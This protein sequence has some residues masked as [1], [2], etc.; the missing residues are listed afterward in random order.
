MKCT[1]KSNLDSCSEC[2]KMTKTEQKAVK[3]AVHQELINQ[4]KREAYQKGIWEMYN[5]YGTPECKNLHHT[6]KHQHRFDEDCPVE[7]E[8]LQIVEVAKN[9]LQE[10]L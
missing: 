9:T 6:K 1:C 7:N 10:K 3:E 2:P 4:A 8:I 5:L